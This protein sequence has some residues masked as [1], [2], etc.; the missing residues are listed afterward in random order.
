MIPAAR[1]R[2]LAIA[3]GLSIWALLGVGI[4]VTRPVVDDSR[5]PLVT[6]VPVPEREFAF[7]PLEEARPMPALQFQDAGGQKVTLADFRGRTVLLNIWA[8][9]CVPCRREMPSLDRLQAKLGGPEFEVVALAVDAGGVEAIKAFFEELD[10]AALRIYVDPTGNAANDLAVL[11]LPTTILVDR[12]GREVG[13]SVGP[14]KWDGPE[15]LQ[16]ICK[17]LAEPSVKANSSA[18]ATGTAGFAVG[19][20]PAACS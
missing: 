3:T 5:R 4:Y 9:W 19:A 11:G 18:A 6:V 1:K 17:H 8:T 13:R 2:R 14:E 16:L 15:A 7:A 20:A 10:V 12:H